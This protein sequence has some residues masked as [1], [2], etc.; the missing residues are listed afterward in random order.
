MARVRWS[1]NRIASGCFSRIS[2]WHENTTSGNINIAID[3]LLFSSHPQAFIGLTEAGLIDVIH[4]SGNPDTHLVLRGGHGTN[5]Q[6]SA[7]QYAEALLDS[8]HLPHRLLI[9]CSHGNS[10]KNHASQAIVLQDILAQKTAGNT[11]IIG[12]ML[13]S[14]LEAGHQPLNAHRPLRYG[15]SVTDSCM[16][17]DETERLIHAAAAHLKGLTATPHHKMPPHQSVAYA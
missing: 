7:I 11:S 5:Y 12:F 15:V 3:S 16:S 9:D 13:E 6:K 8:H 4:A 17:W 2:C 10:S 14:F 1:L